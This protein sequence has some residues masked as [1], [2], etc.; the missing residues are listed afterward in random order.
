MACV[1]IYIYIHII[2]PPAQDDRITA[3][4]EELGL[5]IPMHELKKA[6]VV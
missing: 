2:V 3:K 6:H 4:M 1:Y 5:A